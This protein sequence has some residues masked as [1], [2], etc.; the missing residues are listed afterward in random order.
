VNLQQLK[1]MSCVR[2]G[3]LQCFLCG[4]YFVVVKTLNDAC[5]Y[6]VCIETNGRLRQCKLYIVNIIDRS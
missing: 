3:P 6:D 5:V 1:I 2:T 4:F